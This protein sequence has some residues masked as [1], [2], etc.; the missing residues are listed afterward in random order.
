[1]FIPKQVPTREENIEEESEIGGFRAHMFEDTHIPPCGNIGLLVPKS[2][3]DCQILAKWCV[4]KC[5]HTFQRQKK[6]N[7]TNKSACSLVELC[8]SAASM[9]AFVL[10]A[11]Y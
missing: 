8:T 11:Y 9:A 4:S 1:M 7:A 10:S 6:K 3:I 2:Y 5:L